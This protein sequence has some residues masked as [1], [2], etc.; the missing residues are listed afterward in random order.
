[1]ATKGYMFAGRDAA[2]IADAV[3]LVEREP[4]PVG[5]TSTT[6]RRH[7]P[8]RFVVKITGYETGG[9]KYTGE[10]MTA[11]ET[12]IDPGADLVVDE[13]GTTRT[14]AY[15]TVVVV[16]RCELDRG[17]I[18][19][20]ALNSI[21]Q[22]DFIRSQDNDQTTIAIEAI[23]D[24]VTFK[25]VVSTD[26][27][28]AGSDSTTCDFTYTATAYGSGDEL[29][30]ELVPTFNVRLPLVEYTAGTVGTGC[31]I[32]GSFELLQVN[33]QPDAVACN[34]AEGS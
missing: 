16:N 4:N 26:G 7:T 21:W 17:P 2:R 34:P 11:P 24:P 22:G 18:H 25:V 28:A 9:G 10:I 27:G 32:G 31:Y 33:E 14:A 6:R 5:A 29:G 20:L 3:K 12:D 1:M 8:G 19:L 13:I 23:P 30:T 15:G